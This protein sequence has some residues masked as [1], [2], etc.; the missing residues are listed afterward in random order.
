LHLG[1]YEISVQRS[2]SGGVKDFSQIG[3]QVSDLNE[4]SQQ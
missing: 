1:D 3:L 4:V 2:F